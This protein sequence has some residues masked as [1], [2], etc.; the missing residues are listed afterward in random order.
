MSEPPPPTS[1]P[2]RQP[3]AGWYPDPQSGGRGFRWWDGTTWTEIW[4][5]Q[6][7]TKTKAESLTPIG[8]WLGQLIRT[9]TSRAGH[10]LPMVVILVVPTAILNGHSAWVAFRDGVLTSDPDTEALAYSNPDASTVWYVVAGGSLVL[11]LAALVVLSVGA[12]RQADASL[13]EEPEEWSVSVRAA[14]RRSHRALG[15]SA[16]L[17]AVLIGLYGLVLVSATYAPVLI[18][19]AFPL[20]LVGSAVV[21]VRFSL[22]VIVASLAPSNVGCLRTSMTLSRSHFWPLMGRMALLTMFS[23]SLVLMMQI[24]AAPFVAIGGGA[25]TTPIDLSADEMQLIDVLGDNP[26]VFAIQQLF[27][28]LAYGAAMVMWAVGF[29]LIYRDLSG[30]REPGGSEVV[31][32]SSS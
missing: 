18:L 23:I 15:V 31:G 28:G 13:D 1:P 11:L 16:V 21:S 27:N 22:A 25:G 2:P 24:I 4:T 6:P 7:E 10:Y 8:D 12:A 19:V 20:W 29:V 32:D 30:P 3:P 5:E 14:L 9:V 17:L 26:A